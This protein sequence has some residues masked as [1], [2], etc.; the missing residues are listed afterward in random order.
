MSAS[1]LAGLVSPSVPAARTYMY[2]DSSLLVNAWPTVCGVGRS[3]LTALFM[4]LSANACLNSVTSR[5]VGASLSKYSVA[6]KDRR[7]HVRKFAV[8]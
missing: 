5:G 4:G 8:I 2:I 7:D 1:A 6:T 3:V